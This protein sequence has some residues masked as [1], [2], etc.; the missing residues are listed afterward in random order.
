V[1]AVFSVALQKEQPVAA[2]A[3][4]ATGQLT[5]QAANGQSGATAANGQPAAQPAAAPRPKQLANIVPQTPIARNIRTNK[6]AAVPQTVKKSGP[7]LGRNDPCWCG[8]GKKYKAC[9]MA[10]DASGATTPKR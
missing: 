7:Q 1:K 3:P 9:H 5:A 6:D 2:Q 8:S 4:A 10:S